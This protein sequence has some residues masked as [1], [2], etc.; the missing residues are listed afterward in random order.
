MTSALEIRAYLER[1]NAERLSALDAGLADDPVYMA[2]LDAD[3][4]I[5]L[6]AY[7]MLAV[8]EIASLRAQLSGP[9][10]G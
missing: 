7:V 5:A 8:V 4:A 10:V 6:E 2:E 3:I 9:L 1:L